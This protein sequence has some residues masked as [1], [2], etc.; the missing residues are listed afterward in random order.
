LTVAQS[1]GEAE[2]PHMPRAA[3]DNGGVILVLTLEEI[4][5]GI[6]DLYQ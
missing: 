5:E 1:P 6:L 4:Q 2:F 3:I